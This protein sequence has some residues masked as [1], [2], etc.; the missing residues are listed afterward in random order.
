MDTNDIYGARLQ[1]E[2]VIGSLKS[3]CL[4]EEGKDEDKV[5]MHDVLRNMALWIA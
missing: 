3:A 1:G 2:L 5:K 4:L